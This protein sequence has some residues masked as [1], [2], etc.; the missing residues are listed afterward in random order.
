MFRLNQS[1]NNSSASQEVDTQL[2]D[3]VQ[4]TS[5]NSSNHDVSI[6]QAA[7]QQTFVDHKNVAENKKLREISEKLHVVLDIDNTVST[8]ERASD[9]DSVKKYLSDFKKYGITQDVLQFPVK[10]KGSESVVVLQVLHPGAIEY[11]KWLHHELGAR[12]SFFSSGIEERNTP[13]AKEFLSLALGTVEYGRIK[14]SVSVYS[15][16]DLISST[17]TLKRIQVQN[18]GGWMYGNYKK[19]LKVTL[20]NGGDLTHTILVDD[21]KSYICPGQETNSLI[22]SSI[23]SLYNFKSR[24]IE[25][26]LRLNNIFYI[27]GILKNA[28]EMTL[29]GGSFL[30]NL[31]KLQFKAKD[32]FTYESI[33]SISE[34]RFQ[35]Y[36]DGLKELQK[37]NPHL[38]FY[39]A[40][41][42]IAHFE[43]SKGSRLIIYNCK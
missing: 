17:E 43:R 4:N 6:N 13:F 19:D 28:L 39:G 8:G 38:K 41:K 12:I 21:D 37:I 18:F 32:L 7:Q 33:W 10:E 14:D 3:G 20:K 11:V 22:A 2:S 30:N 1:A 27:T 23:S 16:G 15:R 24:G 29:Q 36:V 9:E 34:D 5:T 42:L 40:E 25:D 26:L 35:Y 31:F